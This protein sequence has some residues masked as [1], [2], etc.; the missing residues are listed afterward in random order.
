MFAE[1]VLDLSR[2]SD[3]FWALLPEIVLS[4]WAMG[5]LLVDVFQKGNRSEPSR[6]MIPWLSIAGL[7]VTAVANAMLLGFRESGEPG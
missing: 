3:Y 4:L 7:A 5:V 2:Q 1:R 6:P